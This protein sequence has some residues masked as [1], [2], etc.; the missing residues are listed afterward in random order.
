MSCVDPLTGIAPASHVHFDFHFG[1]Q[2]HVAQKHSPNPDAHS[3]LVPIRKWRGSCQREFL[4][5]SGCLPCL[6]TNYLNRLNSVCSHESWNKLLPP[7][8][9]ATLDAKWTEYKRCP[10]CHRSPSHCALSCLCSFRQQRGWDKICNYKGFPYLQATTT[11][12]P[13]RTGLC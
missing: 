13:T 6:G 3:P 4:K 9:P 2:F 7:M 8:K 11:K 1:F 10:C 5:V 12:N